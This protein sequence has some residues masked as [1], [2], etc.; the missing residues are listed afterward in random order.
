[1]IINQTDDLTWKSV[2]CKT[3]EKTAL[4]N[5]WNERQQTKW[6]MQQISDEYDKYWLQ[7]TRQNLQTNACSPCGFSQLSDL[8]LTDKTVHL[9]NMMSLVGTFSQIM[10]G[11]GTKSTLQIIVRNLR[12]SAIWPCHFLQLSWVC[13]HV[14]IAKSSIR[15][16]Q[17]ELLRYYCGIR[18]RRFMKGLWTCRLRLQ[19]TDTPTADSQ[20]G[21]WTKQTSSP[22]KWHH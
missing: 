15:L 12:M 1:M 22:D 10:L 6:M 7:Q 16:E 14:K 2:V 9:R 18:N 4:P 8:P 20:K 13:R 5:T 17:T 11:I 19:P 3:Q 21:R